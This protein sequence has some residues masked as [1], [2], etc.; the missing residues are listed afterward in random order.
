[1]P[2]GLIVSQLKRVML[3]YSECIPAQKAADV[4][5]TVWAMRIASIAAGM[6]GRILDDVELW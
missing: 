1:M 6:G 5:P 4:M 3:G 2:P